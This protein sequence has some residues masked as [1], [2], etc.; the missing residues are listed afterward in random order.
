MKEFL[1]LEPFIIV[2][3]ILD[4]YLTKNKK[5]RSAHKYKSTPYEYRYKYLLDFITDNAEKLGFDEYTP[6]RYRIIRGNCYIHIDEYNTHLFTF[7]IDVPFEFN[8]T[9]SVH[10]LAP[11]IRKNKLEFAISDF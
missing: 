7:K 6:N 5:C 9:F 1:G 3:S 2:K 4:L 11:F 8:I 10:D